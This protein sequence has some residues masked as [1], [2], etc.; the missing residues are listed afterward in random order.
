MEGRYPNGIVLAITNC[1]DPSK[2][3]EFNYWYNH[4]H[5]PDVTGFGVFRHMLRY[6]NANPKP[7]EGKYLATCEIG[8][9]DVL[10]AFATALP[11]M[12]ARLREQGRYSPL[13]QGVVPGVVFKRLGGEF[14]AASR[15][16]RGI[17]AMLTNCKDPAREEEFNRWYNDVHIP[18]VLG[19]GAYHTAYRYE[20]LD[21]QVTKGKYLAL[22]E[23]H[24]DNPTKAR[25]ELGK[26]R[27]N[28]ERRER[29]FDSIEVVMGIAAGRIWPMD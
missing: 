13:L 21:P 3:D 1:S 18:D 15:P 25:E 23:T 11:E 28:W 17:L 27:A 22:Y 5:V 14:C 19:I 29:L 20:S 9:D 7:G 6:I 2:E 26:A 10:G 24:Y 8:Q 12:R 16:T 4:I